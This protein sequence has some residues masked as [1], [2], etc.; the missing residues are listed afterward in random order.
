MSHKKICAGISSKALGRFFFSCLVLCLAAFIL[1]PVTAISGSIPDKTVTVGVARDGSC[2]RYTEDLKN[3]K[4]ALAHLSAGAGKIVFKEPSALNCGWDASSVEKVFTEAMRDE[5]FDIVLLQ[6]GML[7][8]HAARSAK[9][10]KKPVISAM[11]QDPDVIGIPYDKKTGYPV[12]E[13]FT[14]LGFPGQVRSDISTFKKIADLSQLSV[15]FDETLLTSSP[16]IRKELQKTGKSLGLEITV[17]PAGEKPGPVLKEL[18]PDT[19]AVYLTPVPR[20]APAGRRDLIKSMTRRKIPSFSLAGK[21]DV[22]GGAF[23]SMLPDMSVVLP[24]WTALAVSRAME[25]TPDERLTVEIQVNR[26]LAVNKKTASRTGLL[27][28][29]D[30]EGVSALLT[31]GTARAVTDKKTEEGGGTPPEDFIAEKD[32]WTESGGRGLSYKKAVKLA[33]KKNIDLAVKKQQVEIVRQQRD[34]ELTGLLPQVELDIQHSRIDSNKAEA[35]SEPETSWKTGATLSQLIFSDPVLSAYRSAAEMVESRRLEREALRLDV[36]ES[37]ESFFIRCLT[38]EAFLEIELDNLSLSRENLSIARTRRR[39]GVSGRSDVYRW[40]SRIAGEE[41]SVLERDRTLK[42]SLIALNKV[43]GVTQKSQWHLEKISR[44]SLDAGFAAD[45]FGKFLEDERSVDVLKKYALETALGHSPE[46]K[47]LNRAVKSR[48]ILLRQ[49]KRSFFMP[50]ISAVFDYDHRIDRRYAGMT[51][52]EEV[53]LALE[54]LG[55]P[56]GAGPS[57]KKDHWM[58]G[59]KASLP[60]FSGGAKITDI[61]RLNAETLRIKELYARA[62]QVVEEEVYDSVARLETS[63]PQIELAGTASEMAKKDLKIV[64][65]RYSEG[66]APLIELLDAQNNAKLQEQALVLARHRYQQAVTA[67]LR[68]VAWRSFVDSGKDHDEW[69]REL[70]QR[71]RI[72]KEIR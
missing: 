24:R 27:S 55:E 30:K 66:K 60:I 18:G 48:E 5:R 57:D 29:L 53:G 10:F 16:G 49:K 9:K 19:R 47:A 43:M 11:T 68:A 20:M 34:R 69:F 15:V 37:T 4:K 13:N 35:D 61:K 63:R 67:F 45:A 7:T 2:A 25:G 52:S 46:M 22:R 31:V 36:A 6:G 12:K 1:D 58:L 51:F 8:L 14:F 59:I 33:E 64:K 65:D 70:A 38:A 42:S 62:L 21:G 28:S 50:E 17:V 54:D 39:V 56:L 26:Q 44:G 72:N 40:R 71:I 23:G 3:T 32:L 41:I